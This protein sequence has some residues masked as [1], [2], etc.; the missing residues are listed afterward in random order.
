[1]NCRKVSGP[2]TD[3]DGDKVGD[4]CDN[5]TLA[6]NFDQQDS[7]VNGIGD[8]CQGA[9]DYDGDTDKDGVRNAVDNCPDNANA[10]ATVGGKQVDTDEDGKGDACDNCPE[11]PNYNQDPEACAPE[12]APN[13][14][15]D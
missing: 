14:D 4:A 6:A 13:A 9:L 7:D 11:N 1:D 2:Q 5:C 15:G 10:P 8:A 3:T 12:Q